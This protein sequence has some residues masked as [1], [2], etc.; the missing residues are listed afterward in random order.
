M[1][2]PNDAVLLLIDVQRAFD[3]P[4]WGRRNNPSAETNIRALLDNWRAHGAAVI[5]V[6]HRNPRPGS[7]FNPDGPGVDV[8]PEAAPV[9][10]EPVLFKDVNSAF[11]GTD[12]EER[13]RAM[14]ATTLVIAGLTTDHCV[15]TTVR[16]AAN[17]GF[18]PFVVS[19][20][21]ATFDRTGP[22]GKHFDAELMHETAL[23]SLHDEFAQIVTT[24][25]A[26]DA[27]KNAS[28]ADAARPNR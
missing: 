15:S 24:L 18:F 5:H 14:G 17:L 27:F 21:T 22:D 25:Q 13:L 19:D 12:L 8:K 7:L 2:L 1:Q 28:E 9:P 3:H 16:M 10:G 20:A 11:I 23:T 26:L 6:H 4:R